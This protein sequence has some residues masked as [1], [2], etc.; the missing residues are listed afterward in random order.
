M[1]KAFPQNIYRSCRHI[2]N[3]KPIN[4]R[5]LCTGNNLLDP[6]DD[7]A[8][9]DSEKAI[10]IASHYTEILKLLGEDINREG[11]L[12]TPLRAAKAMQF[13]SKGY[14]D[15]LST[16]VN[17]AIFCENHDEM[18]IVKNIDFHS[19]CEHHLVPF[20][21]RIHLAYLPNK[22]VIGLSKLARIVEMYCRRLQVQERLTQQIAD[23]IHK[24]LNPA[25]VA[26][27]IEAE[28]MCMTMRGVRKDHA[29]TITSRML[30]EFR[31]NYKTRT[32]FL[33]LITLNNPYA[34]NMPVQPNYNTII[35]AN[36]TPVVASNIQTVVT[37]IK[38]VCDTSKYA[39]QQMSDGERTATIEICKEDIKF[40]CAH[41]TIFSDSEREMIHGHTFSLCCNI[42]GKV[43]SNGMMIDYKIIKAF[44]RNICNE[45]DEKFL[46]PT[47]S[48]YLSIN[49]NGQYFDI[50]FNNEKIM[51]ILKKEVILLPIRNITGEEL[52]NYLSKYL[53]N[54][55]MQY[56]DNGDISKI[57]VSV[58]ASKGQFV[59]SC[60]DC[61]KYKMDNK[62][63]INN[64]DE[65]GNKDIETE[66][67]S[68]VCGNKYCIVTGG[69]TGIG[70]EICNEFM[71]NGYK[72]INLSRSKCDINGVENIAIDLLLPLN[73]SDINNKMDNILN[74]NTKY[75]IHLIHCASN[76]IC[77]N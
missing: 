64:E 9:Y 51:Q 57:S 17:D 43:G 75:E 16:V 76:N 1:I 33:S 47:D 14:Y 53:E 12:K 36:N 50:V 23:D 4:I 18:I 65:I 62:Y 58:S 41:V 39:K 38:P 10:S 26:C 61:N 52:S 11:L 3:I 63:E 27:I 37:D 6:D 68:D 67:K 30:G 77:D 21:G 49:E 73:E 66:Y 42:N 35:D 15:N 2:I 24:A 28:H 69:S 19:L 54:N 70:Y 72:I 56:I 55:L 60:I 71:K 5:Y 46:I 59:T 29:T 48:M 25:G 20:R 31:D 74:K 13:F 22:N 40:S 44:L 8:A 7:S 34:Y 45:W 32:E